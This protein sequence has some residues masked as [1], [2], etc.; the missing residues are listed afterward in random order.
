MLQWHYVSIEECGCIYRFLPSQPVNMALANQNTGIDSGKWLSIM[1]KWV[2]Y[3]G[4]NT[5]HINQA[6]LAAFML[7]DLLSV[8]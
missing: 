6:H 1:Q 2:I 3:G 7:A 5:G 8:N 4:K